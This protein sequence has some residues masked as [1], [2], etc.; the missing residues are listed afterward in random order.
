M[1]KEFKI[2]EKYKKYLIGLQFE[3][4]MLYTIWNTDI[5]NG[6]EGRTY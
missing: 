1:N 2:S 6:E 4:V 5:D 3:E